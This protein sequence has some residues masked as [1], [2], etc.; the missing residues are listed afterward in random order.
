[1]D[2]LD[3]ADII[4]SAMIL[5]LKIERFK[6][7]RALSIPCKRVNV[8]IGPP[9]TGKTNI[10][11]GLQLLSRLGWSLPLDTSLRLRP[12]LGFDALFFRQFFDGPL[13]LEVNTDDRGVKDARAHV[14][15]TERRLRFELP[16]KG[17]AF[18]LEFGQR[19]HV[20]E[21]EW[22]RFYSFGG[23]EHWTY[24]AA[25]A[26]SL[27]TPPHGRNL[28]YI[29]RHDQ[30]AY[31]FLKDL[32]AGINWKLRFDQNTKTFRLSEVRQDE[33]LDY[34]LESLSDSLRRLFFYSTIIRTSQNAALVF[35][36]PDVYAFPPYPK[37]LGDMIA[38]DRSNQYF[39][40]THNPYFLASLVEKT[41][42]DELAVFVCS[43][44]D[45]GATHAT[46]V[47]REKLPLIVEH[48]A[49][50]FFNLDELT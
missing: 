49:S 34:P 8:L 4:A 12:E 22:M 43:R 44:D 3:G 31:D 1:M 14:V 19:Q 50:V 47:P 16:F 24:E 46:L 17:G 11:E 29:A 27:V 7:V 30:R 23:T 33:I 39:L 45:Q 13:K 41:P 42:A 21:F 26:P 28:L 5:Q 37:T 36:E 6:S 25:P 15:G 38:D 40:G 48:G 2:P 9:D 35:D 32:V 10:L 20:P 18:E